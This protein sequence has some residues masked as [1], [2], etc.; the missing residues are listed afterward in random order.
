MN[1]VSR[2]R[3]FMPQKAEVVTGLLLFAIGSWFL[4]QAYNGRG[5]DQP[6]VLRPFSFW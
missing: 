4:Y 5:R 3:H 2:P 1:A 6:K